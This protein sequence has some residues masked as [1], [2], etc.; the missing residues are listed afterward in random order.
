MN[1]INLIQKQ[2]CFYGS[3]VIKMVVRKMKQNNIFLNRTIYSK[4]QLP[5]QSTYC[6]KEYALDW[7]ILLC[8]NIAP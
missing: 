7:D 8:H 1:Q 3:D 4:K 5:L 2:D 6:C